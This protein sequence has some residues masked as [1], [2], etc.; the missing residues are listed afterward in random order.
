LLRAGASVWARS[1]AKAKAKG[2]AERALVRRFIGAPGNEQ[3]KLKPDGKV[4]KG[5]WGGEVARRF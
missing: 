3:G 4:S 1:K 5:V 2:Q